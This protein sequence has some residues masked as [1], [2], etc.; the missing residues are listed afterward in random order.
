MEARFEGA[1]LLAQEDGF[2]LAVKPLSEDMTR[3][4]R[5]LREEHKGTQ[6]LTVK[7]YRK[8][9]SLTANAYA[10]VLLDKLAEVIG[11]PKEDIYRETIRNMGGISVETDIPAEQVEPMIQ[12]WPKGHTGRMCEDLGPYPD[13]P[14]EHK[15]LFVY[16]SSDYDTAQMA[17]F[18]DLLVQ[19]CAIQ[20]IDTMSDQERSLLLEKWDAEKNKGP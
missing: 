14:N 13:N 7:Q 5:W 4:R 1:K 17:R 9:R 8:K 20:G 10:W 16:G 6:Q 3:V 11:I 15:V 18:I 19:E 12:A 2:W